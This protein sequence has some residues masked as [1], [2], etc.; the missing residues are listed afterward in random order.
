M[1]TVIV[2]F[3]VK[4]E[5]TVAFTEAT[6]AETR[7]TLQDAGVIAVDVLQAHDEPAHFALHEVFESRAVGLAHLEMPHFKAWQQTIK[8]LLVEPPHAVAYEHVF[9]AV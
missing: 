1:L 7:T 2:T 4:P 3:K 9:P 8:P 5:H 6:V